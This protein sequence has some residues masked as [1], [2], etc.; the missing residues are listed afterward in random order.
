[1]AQDQATRRFAGV[2]L[3]DT[4]AIR[5]AVAR[6]DREGRPCRLDVG[7]PDWVGRIVA[8]RLGL[9]LDDKNTYREHARR[10]GKLMDI[11]T[12]TGVLVIERRLD[13][14]TL[15]LPKFVLPGKNWKLTELLAQQRAL[16]RELRKA[17]RTSSSSAR[18]DNIDWLATAQAPCARSKTD[19][20]PQHPDG[21]S[22]WRIKTT[23]SGGQELRVRADEARVMPNGDLV[24]I[25]RLEGGRERVN[26]A[27][28][29]GRWAAVYELN[30]EIGGKEDI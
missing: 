12:G 6:A 22:Y 3:E 5:V 28:A 9:D 19:M 7:S 24:L 27:L 14:S 1:M 30:A 26:L 15:E 17:R 21:V 18:R 8:K 11:W 4:L 29:R 16:N 20:G 13:P 25:K 2:T 23:F 10:I